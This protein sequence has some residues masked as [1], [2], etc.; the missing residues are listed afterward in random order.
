MTTDAKSQQKS[1]WAAGV[2]PYAQ[3]GCWQPD[4]DPKDT[5]ILRAFRLVSQEDVDP[6]EA[7]EAEDILAIRVFNEEMPSDLLNDQ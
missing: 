2:I 1:R 7:I 5:D 6:I 3:M 4:Y